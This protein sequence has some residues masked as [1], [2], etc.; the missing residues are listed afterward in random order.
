MAD[1]ILEHAA[2]DSKKFIIPLNMRLGG[3][4]GIAHVG[5]LLGEYV[6]G[7]M[8]PNI[9][10]HV[11]YSHFSLLV[12]FLGLIVCLGYKRNHVKSESYPWNQAF[13]NGVSMSLMS[14]VVAGGFAWILMKWI[15]PTYGEVMYAHVAETW[16]QWLYYPPTYTVM[17]FFYLLVPGTVMSFILAF[18]MKR[19]K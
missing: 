2:A 11:Q 19:G 3:A 18:V 8:G 7:Y 15:H 14:A 1:I 17:S 12:L 6:M 5:W 13:S 4:I 10:W 9:A 16:V